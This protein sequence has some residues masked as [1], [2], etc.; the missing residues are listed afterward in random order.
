MEI[1]GLVILGL[2]V[3]M[4]F[5]HPL[6]SLSLLFKYWLDWT[7]GEAKQFLID[8]KPDQPKDN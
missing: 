2:C 6:K 7:E 5:R 3:W 8:D 4:I 1:V